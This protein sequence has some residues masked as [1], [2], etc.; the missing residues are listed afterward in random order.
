MKPITITY[1]SCNKYLDRNKWKSFKNIKGVIA[2]KI[3]AELPRAKLSFS[4]VETPQ[5]FKEKRENEVIARCKGKEHVVK[6][7]LKLGKC[8]VCS[9][10]GTEYY[11]AI[12]QVRSSKLRLLEE[13]VEVLKRRVESL[14]R[15][16][17]FI[18][19]V[20]KLEDGYD[21]YLTNKRV[22]QSLGRELYETYGGVYKASPHL[23][24]RSRQT[25]K[26]IYRLNVFVR[27]PGFEKGDVILSDNRVFRVEK[28]GKKIKLLDLK[29]NSFLSVD[30]S[31]LSYHVLKKHSTYVSRVHP[32]LEVINP[33]DYQSSMVKNKPKQH[34]DVGQ[35]VN[36]VV[37]QGVYIVD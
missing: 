13:S 26:N 5:A 16:G 18:N 33:F 30:Y 15:K 21:L 14:R 9:K 29:K 23:Y 2:K 22:A 17:V 4:R 6:I 12:L 35:E 20:K 19:K 34:L 28:T 11:E 1:C 31:K 7:I 36:V 8:D 25:S 3:R 37:H 27:L 10:E 32:D 24:S